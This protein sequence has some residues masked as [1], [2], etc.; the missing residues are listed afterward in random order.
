M[1]NLQDPEKIDGEKDTAETT[2]CKGEIDAGSFP[3]TTPGW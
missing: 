1:R 3:E 2:P